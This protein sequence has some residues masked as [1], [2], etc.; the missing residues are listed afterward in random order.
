MNL[1]TSIVNFMM[2][3]SWLIL[4]PYDLYFE[5]EYENWA[6]LKITDIKIDND[7]NYKNKAKH[8]Q[9]K[10]EICIKRTLSF[11]LNIL[12]TKLKQSIL[13]NKKKKNIGNN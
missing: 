10:K 9:K 11:E 12:F 7:K 6:I 1:S 2:K 8:T 3:L 13:L 5:L 4:T